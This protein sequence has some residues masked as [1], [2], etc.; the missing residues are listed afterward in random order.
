MVMIVLPAEAEKT[1][2]NI[3]INSKQINLSKRK[4]IPL[5]KALMK[6]CDLK[7]DRLCV[8]TSTS[9]KKEDY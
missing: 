4:M 9:V 2:L 3:I 1:S 8:V 7:L 5:T 6:K